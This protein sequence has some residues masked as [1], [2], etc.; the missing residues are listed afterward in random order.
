[1]FDLVNILTNT[2]ELCEGLR[3][4]L[5]LVGIVVLAIKIA[6]PIILIVVGMMDLAK[7]VMGKNEDE[8][9]KAQQGLIKKAIAAVIVFLVASLVGV[10][11]SLVGSDDYKE[12]V[13]CINNP[14]GCNDSVNTDIGA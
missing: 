7:A 5:R 8:I 2:K 6:V 3:P 1:M 4:V 11:M 13:E 14:W 10:L 9:K 12:C